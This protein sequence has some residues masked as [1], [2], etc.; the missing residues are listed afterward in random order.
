[1][2][3]CVCAGGVLLLRDQR[4]EEVI[5]KRAAVVR[6]VKVTKRLRREQYGLLLKISITTTPFVPRKSLSKVQAN[7]Y[8]Y[9]NSGP[10][11]ICKLASY[12]NWFPAELLCNC[13][14]QHCTIKGSQER[15][16]EGFWQA[17]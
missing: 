14:R 8:S 9:V 7:V 16:S 4:K 3:L 12:I 6:S 1:M 13:E 5:A 2:R 17:S 11:R 10:P 15:D